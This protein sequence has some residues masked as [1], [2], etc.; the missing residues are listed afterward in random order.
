MVTLLPVL[1]TGTFSALLAAK[2]I[3]AQA[4]SQD[5]L[6]AQ[7][8][9]QN[10]SRFIGLR[11]VD[12]QNL[13]VIP[14]FTDAEGFGKMPLVERERLLSKFLDRFTLYDSFTIFRSPR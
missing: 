6:L 13:A 11:S 2:N 4:V 8:I 7:S 14:T 1:G 9:A 5:K 12:I 3:Q 10:L